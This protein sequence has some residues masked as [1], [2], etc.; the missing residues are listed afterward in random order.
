[1]IYTMFLKQNGDAYLDEQNKI[2]LL[3]QKSSLVMLEI[4]CS[5]KYV[6]TMVF[7]T[8]NT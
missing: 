4:Y 5:I 7:K 2:Q 6:W 8:V 1:M 3:N